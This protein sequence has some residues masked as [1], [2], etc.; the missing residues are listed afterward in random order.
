[1][2]VLMVFGWWYS[3]RHNCLLIPWTWVYLAEYLD[4]VYMLFLF[5][6]GQIS[7]ILPVVLFSP[8]SALVPRVASFEMHFVGQPTHHKY[9]RGSYARHE[10]LAIPHSMVLQ[11]MNAYEQNSSQV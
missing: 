6:Q 5:H 9:P 2:A 11:C 1:M 3:P 4:F 7:F 8:V 10:T